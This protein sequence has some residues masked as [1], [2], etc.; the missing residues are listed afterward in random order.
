MTFSVPD[1]ELYDHRI[2]LSEFTSL[3]RKPTQAH[4]LNRMR[5]LLDAGW[6]AARAKEA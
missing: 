5:A 3:A 4:T 1:E 2:G 6:K